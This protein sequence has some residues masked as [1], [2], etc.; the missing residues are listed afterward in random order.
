MHL[1]DDIMTCSEG[2]RL[3]RRSKGAPLHLSL[4]LHHRHTPG[5]IWAALTDPAGIEAVYAASVECFHS[6]RGVFIYP[7]RF[8]LLDKREGLRMGDVV[9]V[10]ALSVLNCDS[11]SCQF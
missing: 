5:L 3:L 4:E 7:D 9:D 6:D 11:F 8:F 2:R 10:T 1:D